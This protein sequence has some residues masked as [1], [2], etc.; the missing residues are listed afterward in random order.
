M[1]KLHL[2]RHAKTEQNSISGRDFDRELR[3]SGVQQ[4]NQ[5][6][7][8]LASQIE[9]I[10]VICSS[11][12]RT[13]QTLELIKNHTSLENITYLDSLY[14]ASSEEI[15]KIIIRQQNSN[16]ELLII[17]HNFGISDFAGAALNTDIYLRTCEYLLIEIDIEDWVHYHPKKGTAISKYR[18]K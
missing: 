7:E 12:K 2:L 14:L 15:E 16:D 1:K 18:P 11:A 13:K 10:P 8:R 17:G 3:T 9:G 5:I 4:A 6:G